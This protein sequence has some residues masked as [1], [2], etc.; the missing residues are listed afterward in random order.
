MVTQTMSALRASTANCARCHDHKFDPISQEDYY[1]LQAVFAGV[2]K[3]EIEYDEDLE[4]H[5]SRKRWKRLA[6]AADKAIVDSARG[7]E[8]GVVTEWESAFEGETVTW[9]PL[10]PETFLSAR[11]REFEATGGRFDLVGG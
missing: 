3:G 2:G 8:C 5:R 9:K 6:K 1:S 4:T 10:K 11:H 7:G